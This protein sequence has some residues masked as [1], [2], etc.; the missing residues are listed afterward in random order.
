MFNFITLKPSSVTSCGKSRSF[1]IFSILIFIIFN[2]HAFATEDNKK[3]PNPEASQID[4]NQSQIIITFDKTNIPFSFVLENGKEVGLYVDFWRLWS[5]ENKIPITF[6]PLTFDESISAIKNGSADFHAGLFSSEERREWASFSRPI[7]RVSSGLY[8]KNTNSVLPKLSEMTTQ[9]VAVEANIFQENYLRKNYPNLNIVTFID[10]QKAIHDLLNERIDAIFSEIPYLEAQIAR[11]GIR[12]LFTLGE[13][14]VITNEVHALFLKSKD[15]LISLVDYGIKNIPVNKIIALE[16]RWL[17]KITPYFSDHHSLLSLSIREK[18]WLKSHSNFKIGV[19]HA[20]APFEFVNDKSEYTGLTSEYIEILQQNLGIEITPQLQYSW[21]ES[22]EKLKAGKIDFM[23]T[24]IKTLEHSKHL[25]FTQPYLSLPSVITTREGA[26]YIEGMKQLYGKRVGVVK[27]SIYEELIKRDYPQIKLVTFSTLSDGLLALETGKIDAYVDALAPINQEI[28]LKKF[29]KITV[30]AFIPYDLNITMGVRK[31][32]EE[33]VPILNKAISNL[34]SKEIS[35]IKNRWLSIELKL[36]SGIL[37][38]LYIALP[39]IFI[40][41]GVI[42]FVLKANKKM[43]REI[44]ARYKVEKRLERAKLKAEA[45]NNSKDEFLANMSHEIRTPMNAVLGMSYLLSKT[46]LNNQQND[47]LDS[48]TNSADSLLVLINDILDLSKVEAGKIDLEYRPFSINEL[49]T[50]LEYQINLT[51]DRQLVRFETS[52]SE[53]LPTMLIGD[54]LRLNQIILNLCNNA[55]KFTKNGEIQLSVKLTNKIQ[56]DKLDYLEVLFCISDTGIGMTGEQIEKL[57]KSYSQ[58]DSS[59]TRKYGGTGLGLAICKKLLDIMDG[60]IWVE[61]EKDKGSRFYFTITFGVGNPNEKVVKT[62]D[63]S[64]T[65]DNLP[66][67]PSGEGKKIL[68]VDDNSVNLTIVSKIL[69]REMYTTVT[70]VDGREAIKELGANHY[71]AVLMDIQMPKM[72][73]Y[74]ATI[75]IRKE[76]K[77]LDL[78][79]IALSANV[80]EK[81]KEL[82][83]KAGMDEHLDKP[84][85]IPELLNIL[86]KLTSTK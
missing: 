33:L 23:P 49:F 67:S 6:L 84:I 13:K 21:S 47:Y 36:T 35:E 28:T 27:D 74:Q 9:V 48:L 40:L 44:V 68:I 46:G 45:A 29:N 12:G 58:A 69:E 61:S 59:T 31:G 75:H 82:S 10:S 4:I 76:L 16:K 51:L 70:A 34:S 56:K 66:S 72:D 81:D 18:Q 25:L 7:H 55:V 50:N 77:L 62:P 37:E 83:K 17:P 8:F 71:D 41:L 39:V 78:P 26:F 53:Q 63:E 54:G 32:L 2:S 79:I 42:L 22:L 73:G 65:N 1:F 30:A 80:M 57:F 3:N 15:H 19:D 11:I 20:W 24:V 5:A 38:F 86:H 14:Q 52:I 64:K 60:E 43:K 85:N